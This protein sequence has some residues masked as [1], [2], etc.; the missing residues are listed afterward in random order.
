MHSRFCDGV[1]NA[2]PGV[3]AVPVLVPCVLVFN[4]HTS[5]EGPGCLSCPEGSQRPLTLGS[6]LRGST[7]N[8]TGIHEDAGSIPDLAQWLKDLALP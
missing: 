7:I 3:W 2:R 4:V 8:P 1:R 5:W 6:F